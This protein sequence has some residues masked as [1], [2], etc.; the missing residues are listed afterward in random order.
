MSICTCRASKGSEVQSASRFVGSGAE[1]RDLL[2][3]ESD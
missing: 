2:A 1:H 3:F